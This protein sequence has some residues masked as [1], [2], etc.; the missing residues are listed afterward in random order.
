[1]DLAETLGEVAA[2][3]YQGVEFAGLF[4]HDPADIRSILDEKGLKATSTMIELDRLEDNLPEC[5]SEAATLGCG[6]IVVPFL[7]ESQRTETG[8]AEAA[9]AMERIAE[10]IGHAG[11]NLAYHH[12]AFE[13]ELIAE[14]GTRG[15]DILTRETNRRTMLEVD[16][17][18]AAIGGENPPAFLSRNLEKTQ[19]VHLKDVAADPDRHFTEIGSGTLDFHAILRLAVR[20]DSPVRWLLVEQDGHFASSAIESVRQSYLALSRLLAKVQENRAH[21]AQ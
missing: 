1:M 12:H 18:W 4:G 16:V 15:I 7:P 19:M 5:V 13:F 14:R 21:G 10:E 11:L 20:L 8:Y 2:I 9:K 3:G 6:S 17:Y